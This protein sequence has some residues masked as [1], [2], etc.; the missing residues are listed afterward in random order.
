MSR[1]LGSIGAEGKLREGQEFFWSKVKFQR[2]RGQ[3]KPKS[4]PG[5]NRAERTLRGERV[6]VKA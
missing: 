6:M 1:D 2:F 3:V 5:G 4:R